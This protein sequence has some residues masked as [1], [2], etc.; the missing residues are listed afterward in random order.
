MQMLLSK[1][2]DRETSTKHMHPNLG[3][4][5]VQSRLP[6]FYDAAFGLQVKVSPLDEGV[7]KG[8]GANVRDPVVDAAG[9]VSGCKVKFKG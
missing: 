4:Y 9:C 1:G 2:I 8:D 6:D 7:P 3:V 5:Q